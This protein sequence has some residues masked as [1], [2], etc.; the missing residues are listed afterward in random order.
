MFCDSLDLS[1]LS[2][3]FFSFVPCYTT[4]PSLASAAPPA[5]AWQ[6]AV[7]H[8]MLALSSVTSARPGQGT[9]KNRLACGGVCVWLGSSLAMDA[10]GL[11]G[12][13]GVC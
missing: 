7:I 12:G 8:A 10:R 5:G 4:P 9:R 1:C 2:F 6:N 3:R 11:A 13:P